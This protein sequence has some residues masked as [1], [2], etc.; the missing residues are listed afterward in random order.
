MV[1]RNHDS[2]VDTSDFTMTDRIKRDDRT[3]TLLLDRDVEKE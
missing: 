2:F 3:Q 1:E